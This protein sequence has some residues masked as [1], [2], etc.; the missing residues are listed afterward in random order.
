MSMPD[1]IDKTKICKKC[2]KNIIYCL[3]NECKFHNFID[4]RCIDCGSDIESVKQ[5]CRHITR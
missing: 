1:I 3:S 5:Y 4:N 2:N